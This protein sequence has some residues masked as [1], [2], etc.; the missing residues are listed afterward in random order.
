LMNLNL[1]RLLIFLKEKLFKVVLI[2]LK[3]YYFYVN[4]FLNN[5]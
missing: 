2:F 1:I 3:N 4:I 5:D